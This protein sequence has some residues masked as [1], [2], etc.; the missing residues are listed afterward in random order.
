M[1]MLWRN[2]L[3]IGAVAGTMAYALAEDL[4]LS[5]Y[6]PS[7]RGVY[8]ELRTTGDV[9]IGTTSA[10]MAR[11]HVIGAGGIAHPFR[12]EDAPGG[13]ATPFVINS[14]GQV[15]IGTSNPAADIKLHVAGTVRMEG[16]QL[17]TSAAPGQV[18][19]ANAAGVGTWQAAGGTQG[20]PAARARSFQD[21]ALGIT[22]YAADGCTGNSKR[23]IELIDH[24]YWDAPG[25]L[26][27]TIFSYRSYMR[28]G[29]CLANVGSL[30][31]AQCDTGYRLESEMVVSSSSHNAF[32]TFNPYHMVYWCI[33][34]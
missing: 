24:E 33:R 31:V 1:R 9:A 22:Y 20:L 27:N 18:L 10:P 23:D 32:N 2:L 29:N 17:G 5:T 25:V 3:I 26:G 19:T 11:L 14:N 7:P 34:E 28:A 12:V 4:T 6:Y 13:D 21:W 8:K 16:F 15:G 30:P